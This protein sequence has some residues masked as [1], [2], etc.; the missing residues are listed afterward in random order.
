MK[1]GIMQPYFFPYIGYWQ[2][3]NAVDRFVIYDNIQFTKKGWIKRNRILM[4]GKDKMISLPIK[5]DSDYLDVN[6]RYLSET[7][8]KDKTKIINQ[9]KMAYC[10]APEFDAV[11][12]LIE[13]AVNCGK[14]N[15]FDFIHATIKMVIDYL[16]ID[17][18]IIISSDIGMDHSLMNRDRVI[19]TCKTLDGEIY[20]NPIGGVELYDKEEFSQNGIELKFIQTDKFEYKQYDNIFVQNLSIIDVMMFNSKEEIKIILNKYKTI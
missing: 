3:I 16:E 5:K 9:I 14:E 8:E 19:E 2:L 17:T 6:K 15:L 4:N 12:P 18:E 10:K 11:F 13:G 20:I 1:I 7:F